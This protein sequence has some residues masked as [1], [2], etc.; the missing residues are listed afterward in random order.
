[1]CACVY[2]RL[3]ACVRRGVR[4]HMCVYLQ[5]QGRASGALIY[6]SLPY[7]LDMASQPGARL[8]V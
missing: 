5:G 4:M 2:V 7:S 3:C 6:H 8:T 1:M